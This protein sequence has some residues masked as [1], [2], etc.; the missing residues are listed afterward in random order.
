MATPIIELRQVS[1]SFGTKTVLDQ[2]DMKIYE[3]EISTIIGKS[4]TGKSVLLKHI[5]GLLGPDSGTILFKGKPV[6]Q[7]T[8]KELIEFKKQFSYCFQNNALF[9]SMTVLDNIALPLRQTTKMKKKEIERKVAEK[10]DHLEIADA[11]QKY[12]SE[13]SGGMQKRVALARA[14]ITDPKIVLFDEPT[15]GQ[16]PIRK[17]AIFSMITHNQK[18]FG[19]TTVMISHDLPDVFFISDRIMILY[20][21]KVSFQGT[22]E[23][24]SQ[25]QHPIIDEFIKSLEGV[26]DELTGLHTNKQFTR[27]YQS[28]VNEKR[29]DETFSVIVFGLED[30]DQ[31]SQTMGHTSAQE[32]VR[33]LGELVNRH[34]GK[35]GISSRIARDRIA[36]ILPNTGAQDALKL[37]EGIVSE[38]N[39]NDFCGLPLAQP[40]RPRG[41]APIEFRIVGGIAEGSVSEDL[42]AISKRAALNLK[43]I[44]TY[45]CQYKAQAAS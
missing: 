22:Y 20:E 13:L 8:R 19:F 33:A 39:A 40:T 38:L 18:R 9:D 12:P 24:L 11:L 29:A 36:T 2:V 32:V 6:E 37:M 23:E 10:A 27:R 41:G 5:I 35:V 45:H 26:Q 15:T 42:E 3:G 34:F 16:D 1:K 43:P 25:F 30:L 4:G 17:N 21:G 7:M 31:L 28:A 44:A 14:L